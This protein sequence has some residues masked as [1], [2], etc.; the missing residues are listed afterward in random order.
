MT[1]QIQGSQPARRTGRTF[2]IKTLND[3]LRVPPERRRELFDEIEQGLLLYELAWG[4]DDPNDHEPM[5][6]TWTDDG[7]RDTTL[8]TPDGDVLVLK[9]TMNAEAA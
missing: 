1:D 4:D 7:L 2:V 9:V 6:F 8:S 5:E 3:L